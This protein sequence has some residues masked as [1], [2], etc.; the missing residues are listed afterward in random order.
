MKDTGSIPISR[1]LLA[2]G[3]LASL[4][5]PA[6][7]QPVS[8]EGWGVQAGIGDDPDQVLAGV[9]WR[10]GEL[11]PRLRLRPSLELGVGDDHTVLS[12]TLPALYH[13]PLDA[14]FSPYAGGGLLVAF[15]DRDDPGPRRDSNETDISLVVSGGLEWPLT[16]GNRLFLQLDLAGGD[17]HD[18]RLWIGWSF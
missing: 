3:L 5:A 2:L 1:W 4:A 7:A 17:A 9:H 15:I 6:V 11:V 16:S 10:L 13:F 12:A 8:Y 18:A 14:A